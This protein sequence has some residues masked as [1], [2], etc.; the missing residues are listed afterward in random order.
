MEGLVQLLPLVGILLIFWLL[1]IRPAQRRNREQLRMQS[2]LEVGQTVVL[3]A[4]FY[5]IL[6]ELLDD[7]VRVELAPG[8]VVTVARA[9]VGGIV[10]DPDALDAAD[11]RPIDLDKRGTDRPDDLSESGEN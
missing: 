6:R 11:D 1:I 5:G 8:T 10:P 4:G 9:A 2:A 3:T 7:R